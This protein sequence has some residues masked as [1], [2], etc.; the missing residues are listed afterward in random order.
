MGQAFASN[1]IYTE[2][3]VNNKLLYDLGGADLE[4]S[5]LKSFNLCWI[6]SFSTAYV[7]HE[8][9]TFLVVAIVLFVVLNSTGLLHY[10]LQGIKN[11]RFLSIPVHTFLMWGESMLSDLSQPYI[12]YIYF[13]CLS[14]FLHDMSQKSWT[15]ISYHYLFL[16]SLI[17]SIFIALYQ[18]LLWSSV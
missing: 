9:L 8:H 11:L 14:G 2:I 15:G 6:T 7:L 17:H 18:S 12:Y 3:K 16:Q 13:L 5:A 1:H 4:L 10:D